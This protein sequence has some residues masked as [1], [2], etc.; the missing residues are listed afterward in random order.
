MGWE[1]TTEREEIRESLWRFHQLI[2]RE[3]YLRT[4]QDMRSEEFA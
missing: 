3:Y 4:I 1:D 2:R